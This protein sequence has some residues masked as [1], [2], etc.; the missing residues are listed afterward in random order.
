MTYAELDVSEAEQAVR[1]LLADSGRRASMAK[2]GLA[3]VDAKHRDIH[4]AQRLTETLQALPPDIVSRRL[5]DARH[6]HT[7]W[8]RSMYLLFA[9]SLD[10]E[11]LR[12]AYLHAA[13]SERRIPHA[14][15]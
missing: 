7:V 14:T 15:A 11:T 12:A 8:L 3:A 10:S 4:R 2:A 9:E 6:I 13:T 5:A 1:T